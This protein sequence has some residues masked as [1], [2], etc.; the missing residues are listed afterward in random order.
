MLHRSTLAVL[1]AACGVCSAA[2]AQCTTP[3]AWAP[4]TTS[5]E[6]VDVFVEDGSGGLYAGGTFASIGGVPAARV[7][8]WNGS[9]WS[10]LGSGVT[11]SIASVSCLLLTSGNLLVVGGTF[12][13]AGGVPANHIA[14]WNGATWAPL[15]SGIGGFSVQ[16]LVELPNG[17][18]VALGNFT[19]AGGVPAN[20]I[21]RWNGSSWAPLG[22]G[23][24]APGGLLCLAN[25]NLLAGGSFAGTSSFVA[26][27]NGSTWTPVGN[28]TPMVPN[29]FVELG[30]GD[31]LA[32]GYQSVQRWNG[33]T[34]SNVGA[35]SGGNQTTVYD[36]TRHPDGSAIVVGS[37]QTVTFGTATAVRGVARFAPATATWS[38]LGSATA[39][40]PL[41]NAGRVGRALAVADGRVLLGQAGALAGG[42]FASVLAITPGCPATA[43]ASGTGCAGSGGANVLTAPTLPWLGT[44]LTGRCTGLPAG[45]LAVGVFGLTSLN[46]PLASVLT[47]APGCTALVTPD[48]LT[49]QLPVAGVATTSL[50]V[51]ND[52]ALAGGLVRL[53]MVTFESGGVA[54]SSNALAFVIGRL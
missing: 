4:L 21:A 15:G 48:L 52:P 24:T 20:N 2:R 43:T 12:T 6:A 42:T 22:S 26:R 37:F 1:L 35:V 18:L 46:L 53:Q 49:A 45:S 7:A 17:D 32:G 23:I 31:L 44:S 13:A 39:M 19:S 16:R 5:Q 47:A 50:Q 41:G 8:R 10:A 33:A 36:M 34:W 28:F 11:G 14:T 9:T 38:D 51:P 25:G 3:P 40:A 54:T 29:A 30:N 27:W